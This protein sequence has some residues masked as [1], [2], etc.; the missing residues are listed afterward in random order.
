[1]PKSNTMQCAVI[2]R[3]LRDLE[4]DARISIVVMPT[5]RESDG[6][7]RSSR[8]AVLTPSMR[9]QA[10]A[11]YAAL[12]SATQA[13]GATPMSVRTAVQDELGRAGM[14]PIY[15]SVA[16]PNDMREKHDGVPLAGSVVSVAC[17]L[18]DGDQECRLIDNV[19]LQS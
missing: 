15:V 18:R 1:M 4:L 3:M 19:M 13:P 10:P 14:T 9:Q 11:I 16:D 2:K 17:L 12:S 5:S 6:L 7:A 8:N